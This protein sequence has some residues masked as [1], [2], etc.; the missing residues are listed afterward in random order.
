MFWNPMY[1]VHKRVDGKQLVVRC[2]GRVWDTNYSSEILKVVPRKT[3]KEIVDKNMNDW[4]IKWSDAVYGSKWRVVIEIIET[5]VIMTVMLWA[6]HELYI[7][8]VVLLG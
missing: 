5:T 3:W 4:H 6:E 2:Q 1:F 8:D 7:S